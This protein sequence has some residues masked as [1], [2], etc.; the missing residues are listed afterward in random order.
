MA[1]QLL[2]AVCGSAWPRS[3]WPPSS[4]PQYVALPGPPLEGMLEDG[5]D[6]RVFRSSAWVASAPT[7]CGSAWP[8]PQVDSLEGKD[9]VHISCSAFNSIFLMGETSSS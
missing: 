3:A 2:P 4:Y 1:S 7:R 6:T 5:W 8:A 9:I